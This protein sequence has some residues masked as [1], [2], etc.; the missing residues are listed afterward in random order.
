L[1]KVSLLLKIASLMVC[2]QKTR[3]NKVQTASL[4]LGNGWSGRVVLSE[5]SGL[6][7]SK[8]DLSGVAQAKTEWLKC[9]S[10]PHLLCENVE[11]IL[12][13]EG[14]NY[15]AVKNLTIGDTNLKVVIKRHW[16]ENGLRRFFRSLR[17]GKALRNFKTALKL[18]SIGVPAAAPLAA[19][20]QKKGLFTRQS[21]YITQYL[22]ESFTLHTFC[23]QHLSNDFSLRKHLSNQLAA[24]LATLHKNGLWH[25]D[26]KANNFLV[27]LAGAK[28]G[29]AQSDDK[30]V[31]LIDIDGIKPY[32]LRRKSQ[33]FRSLWHLAASLLSIS[34]INRTD[35]HRTFIAY[36]NL[37]GIAPSQRHQIFRRLS[38]LAKAKHL[39]SAMKN[40]LIIKPSS[41]GDI[42][43]ALPALSALRKSFPGAKISW[44]VR[45][46]FAP[47][48]KNHPHLTETILFDRKFL[49]KAWFNPRAFA[50]LVSLIWRLNRSKFDAVIDLQGLFRTA[51]LSWLSGCRKRLGMA[52]AREFGYIFYTHKIAQDKDSIHLVDYYLK[53]VQNAGASDTTVQFVLPVD[54]AA[55]D[56][57]KRLLKTNGIKPNNYA[58]F[59]P[60]SAREDKCWPAECF[61]ALAD[62]VSTKFGLSIIATGSASEKDI[63][64]RLKNL[65]GVPIANFAGATSLSELV[66]LLKAARLVV[67]NDTGPGH[68]A[69]AL[70]VPVVLLFGPTNPAR[71]HPYN[72]PECAVAVEPDGRGM[73]AD[74]TDPKHNIKAITVD[75]VYQKVCEQLRDTL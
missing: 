53:I 8:T 37:T 13:T 3:G 74:S 10:E 52:N 57:V 23:R 4:R 21:I 61:A 15:V 59:V 28:P 39:R 1:L 62:R 9:L 44:L 60:T 58:V 25:R 30:I 32:F 34:A 47:L 65:A 16:P 72:R 51:S 68:I 18:R 54:S 24:I 20:Q 73:K 27:A 38:V 40:I 36:S 49:G 14:R 7:F 69:A 75:E 2:L 11:K 56:A 29:V 46:E 12:K 63:V 41:L 35:Y 43:L 48:L 42:V 5:T 45:P 19:L 50:A 67:S 31:S 33:Q 55:E 26:S 64:E 70:G 66:A 22:E 17:P 6:K 71:V